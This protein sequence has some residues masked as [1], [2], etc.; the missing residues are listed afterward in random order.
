[1]KKIRQL[2][3]KSLNWLAS[4]SLLFAVMLGLIPALLVFYGIYSFLLEANFDGLEKRRILVEQKEEEVR[5]GLGVEMSEQA[6][7]NEF[8]NVVSLLE[9]TLPKVPK[10]SE[11]STVLALV[12][13]LGNSHNV[14]VTS[15]AAANQGVKS[16]NADKLYERELP[17]TAVGKYDDV[18]RFWLDI[19]KLERILIVRDFAVQV[20]KTSDN[21]S[22]RPSVVVAQFSMLAFH[23]PP[24]NEF[25]QLPTNFNAVRTQTASTIQEKQK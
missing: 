17:V 25:P 9:D 13:N 14:K 16:P 15:L 7:R 12:Q 20:P 1:M 18:L 19:S 2:Y 5:K 21:K 11:L 4:W 23:A 24:T 3:S 22:A 6:F 8:R 10:E